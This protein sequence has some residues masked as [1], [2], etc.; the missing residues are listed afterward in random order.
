MILTHE[1]DRV[2]EQQYQE[3]QASICAKMPVRKRGKVRWNCGVDSPW[4]KPSSAKQGEYIPGQDLVPACARSLFHE[5]LS[6]SPPRTRGLGHLG[7]CLAG[8]SVHRSSSNVETPSVHQG[9]LHSFVRC[10]AASPCQ[11]QGVAT[12]DRKRCMDRSRGNDP[13]NGNVN[14]SIMPPIRRPRTCQGR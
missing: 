13:R 11:G 4:R 7:R 12:P 10:G 2:E 8:V 6:S 14:S 3:P 9:A 1:R 5:F